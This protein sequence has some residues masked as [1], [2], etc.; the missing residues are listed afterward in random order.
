[1]ILEAVTQAGG[2]NLVRIAKALI[3]VKDGTN[4][5]FTTPEKYLRTSNIKIAVTW[6]GRR[7]AEGVDFDCVESGG[8]GSGYDTVKLLWSAGELLP[9]SSDVLEADYYADPT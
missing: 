1:M 2:L 7:L 8:A 3:G 4:D 5:T 6:N 9:R